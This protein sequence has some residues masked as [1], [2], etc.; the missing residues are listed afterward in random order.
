[1]ATPANASLANGYKALALHR[2]ALILAVRPFE[3]VPANAGVDSFTATDPDNG[4]AVRVQRVY[5]INYRAVRYGVD[6]LYGVAVLRPTLG[7]V[8]LS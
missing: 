7:S 4:L 8:V 1:M 6:V 3:P 2:D 5:D